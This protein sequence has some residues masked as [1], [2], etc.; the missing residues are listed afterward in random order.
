[1]AKVII[2]QSDGQISVALKLPLL[3]H[4]IDLP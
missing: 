1:M 3:V 2:E 4:T